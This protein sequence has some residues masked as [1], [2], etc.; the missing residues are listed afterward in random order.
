MSQAVPIISV[1]NLKKSFKFGKRKK[2][3]LNN[4][5]FS[6]GQGEWVAIMGPSGCGKT[7][8]LNIIALLDQEFEDGFMTLDDQKITSSLSS[9]ESAFFRSEKIGIVFQDHYLIPHLTVRE[10]VLMPYIWTGEH[11]SRD[12]M[13]KRARTVIE[14]V[15]MTERIDFFPEEIS[16]GEKQRISIARALVRKPK[17]LLLDEP[18][19][20][21]DVKTGK[22]ILALFQRIAKKQGVTIIMVTHDTEA[23]KLSDRLLLLK[24]GS[25]REIQAE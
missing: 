10:N 24:K 2:V 8:L 21:L 18:T 14:M 13:D 6:V 19:G 22:A 20:N 1:S 7:T 4:L 15:G 3:V 9:T 5:S 23:A 16:G 25:L 17:L 11:Y 12:F